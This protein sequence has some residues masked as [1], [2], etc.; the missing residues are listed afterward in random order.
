M[1]F[2]YEI[3]VIEKLNFDLQFDNFSDFT[4]IMYNNVPR[5]VISGQQQQQ[6]QQQQFVYQGAQRV[7]MSPQQYYPG[8]NFY[9]EFSTFFLLIMLSF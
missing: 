3:V 5:T 4:D 8:N 9:R 1:Y 7:Y 2:I 6:Q